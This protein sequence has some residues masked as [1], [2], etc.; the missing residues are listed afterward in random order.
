MWRSSKTYKGLGQA[1][2]LSSIACAA[3]ACAQEP[4]HPHVVEFNVPM[5]VKAVSADASSAQP[6]DKDKG[7]DFF[8]KNA[9]D[10]KANTRWSSI[11]E[12]P[13]WFIIDLG[14][15]FNIDK[16]IISWESAFASSYK[17]NLSEDRI[18]WKEVFSTGTGRGG[19]ETVT[20]PLSK[21]RYIK[22][23]LLKKNGDWGFSV[24]EMSVYGKRKLVL[25]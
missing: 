19:T 24:W 11:F 21:A 22:I 1:I 12:E 20:F 9:I 6:P 7:E 4:Q 17:I 16:L 15:K 23:D 3:L 14:E 25:F 10:G 2:V 5:P 13:Q 8:A 18:S